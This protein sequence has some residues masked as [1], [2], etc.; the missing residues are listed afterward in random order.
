[1]QEFSKEDYNCILNGSCDKES[2][3]AT[4]ETSLERIKLTKT[5]D[6]VDHGTENIKLEDPSIYSWHSTRTDIGSNLLR[7]S[8]DPLISGGTHGKWV[9]CLIYRYE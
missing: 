3:L 2:N 8:D 9:C 1:M 5:P 4:T 6:L 7:S